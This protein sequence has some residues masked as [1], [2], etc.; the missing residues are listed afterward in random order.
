VITI[1]HLA[2]PEDQEAAL[3]FMLKV[4]GFRRMI[5]RW[6]E[7]LVPTDPDHP[8]FQKCARRISTALVQEWL[9]PPPTSGGGDE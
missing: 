3:D 8:D 9:G 1:Q 5:I 2:T 7:Y 6:E 4:I